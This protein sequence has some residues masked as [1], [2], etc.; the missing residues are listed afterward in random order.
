MN[1]AIRTRNPWKTVA[2]VLVAVL[3][4]LV[5]VLVSMLQPPAPT[6][7]G[8]RAVPPAAHATSPGGSGITQDP[9]VERHAE[10]VAAHQHGAPR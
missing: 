2:M 10:V 7:V 3:V 5:M 4:L 1:E 6:G 9:Y 8:G